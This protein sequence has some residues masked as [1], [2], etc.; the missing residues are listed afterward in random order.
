MTIGIRFLLSVSSASGVARNVNWGGLPYLAPYLSS[1]SPRPS[2][3]LLTGVRGYLPVR[4]TQTTEG[5]TC[6]TIGGICVISASMQYRQFA[7]MPW[8]FIDQHDDYEIS[9][10]RHASVVVQVH[11]YSV[12]IHNVPKIRYRPKGSGTICA[13][14]FRP[15]VGWTSAWGFLLVFHS[16]YSTKWCFEL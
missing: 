16:N 8:S 15:P 9:V 10:R 12:H 14:S 2:L 7:D 1:T 13:Q 4:Y 6:V 5:A 11:L 3:P